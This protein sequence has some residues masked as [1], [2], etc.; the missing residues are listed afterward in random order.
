MHGIRYRPPVQ[1]PAAPARALHSSLRPAPFSGTRPALHALCTLQ[2]ALALH[3]PHQLTNYPRPTSTGPRPGHTRTRASVR[4]RVALYLGWPSHSQ[5]SAKPMR[6]PLSWLSSQ[7]LPSPGGPHTLS[8]G[9]YPHSIPS[10][11][12]AAYQC[13]PVT[14]QSLSVAT[15]IH[16][17]TTEMSCATGHQC[18]RA[19][20]PSRP[21]PPR[22]PPPPRA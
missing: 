8:T 9:L 1:R 11:L 16:R 15:G 17:T 7:T 22:P 21:S 19:V 18:G 6:S 13:I 12:P 20:T 4:E 14:V 3:Q 2:A 5:D 10:G